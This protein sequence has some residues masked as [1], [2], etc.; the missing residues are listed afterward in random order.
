MISFHVRNIT[1]KYDNVNREIG[2]PTHLYVLV[3]F[4][5][6]TRGVSRPSR[7]WGGMRWTWRWH[8]TDGRAADGEAVWSWRPWAGAKSAIG[9]AG[10]GDYEVTDTGESTE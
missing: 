5:S 7:A 4:H 9:L 8:R 1:K 10:D 3:L 2:E 6:A